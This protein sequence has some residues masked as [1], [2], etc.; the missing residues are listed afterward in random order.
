MYAMYDNGKVQLK[1]SQLDWP[2]KQ[3]KQFQFPDRIG[4]ISRME[5]EKI[6]QEHTH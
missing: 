1:V 5:S 2:V 6:V 3:K 4:L